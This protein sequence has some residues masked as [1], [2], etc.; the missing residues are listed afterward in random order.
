M[1]Y[2]GPTL[3]TLR[4]VTVIAA[5]DPLRDKLMAFSD[6]LVTSHWLATVGADYGISPAGTS[7][8]VDGPALTGNVTLDGMRDYVRRAVAGAGEQLGPADSPCLYLL[9]LPPGVQLTTSDGINCACD[10]LS[11][12][13]DTLDGHN[14]LA[15]VQRCSNTYEDEN[16]VTAS[17]EIIEA[18]TDPV[19]GTGILLASGAPESF[20]GGGEV[21]DLCAGTQVEEGGWIYQRIWSNTAAQAGGDP[22]VPAAPAP[23]F[24][25][26]AA[27]PWVSA[28]PGQTVQIPLTAWSTAPRPDWYLVPFLG[29]GVPDGTR[30]TVTTASS[31]TID[32]TAFYSINNGQTATL[33]VT[34][35]AKGM[36]SSQPVVVGVLSVSADPR[37]DQHQSVIG[38]AMSQ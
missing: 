12:A 7:Q 33:S 14:A 22:C 18:A 30:A 35:P 27:Q 20:L 26:S 29:S 17:H 3:G 37:E 31:Q 36:D 21:G 1:S 11:G 23:Y 13:H 34:L 2:G 38:I 19:P 10:Q 25:V 6:T 4:L 9:Y 16:S 15:F 24:S 28:A 5:G 8:H 32:G